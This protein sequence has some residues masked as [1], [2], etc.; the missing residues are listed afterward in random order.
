MGMSSRDR[1]GVEDEGDAMA[2]R[3]VLPG[4]D[5]GIGN[6]EAIGQ[7]D[8]ANAVVRG[9]CHLGIGQARLP[10]DGID[11]DEPRLQARRRMASARQR[12]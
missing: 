10:G 9:Q 2:M 7:Q 1:G 8:A 4:A 6:P 5:L 12:R 11:V 3:K